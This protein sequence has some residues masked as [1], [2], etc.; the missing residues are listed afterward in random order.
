MG[1][2]DRITRVVRAHLN[3]LTAK[4]EDPALILEQAVR[5][6]EEDVVTLRSAVAKAI[7]AQKQQEQKIQ[8]S[9]TEKRSWEARAQLA[10]QKGDDE[11]AR[12]ALQ[13]KQSLDAEI[14][15]YTGLVNQHAA[16][17]AALKDNLLKVEAKLAE[18]KTKK[19]MLK[20]RADAAKAQEQLQSI[21]GGLKTSADSASA[22]F[23]R[24]E[25][26]VLQ[27][28]AK[29]QALSELSGADLEQQFKALESGTDVEAELNLLKSTVKVDSLPPAP[30]TPS[31]PPKSNTPRLEPS[32]SEPVKTPRKESSAEDDLLESLARGGSYSK[33]S[34]KKEEPVT[35]DAIDDLLGNIGRGKTNEATKPQKGGDLD[36]DALDRLVSGKPAK[37][38]KPAALPAD[39]KK[40]EPKDKEPSDAV[41]KLMKDLGLD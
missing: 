29:G 19:E 5:E 37:P 39:T 22:V 21:L 16:T 30:V 7:A 14:K 26:Q 31:L 6:M 17:V 34:P 20:A 24:M 10:V 33:Q 4:A 3:D 41:E 1:I 35:H 11:L 40:P 18:A 15:T 12:Q 36:D 27:L 38:Q 23:D 25:E 32:K 28:E 8:T 9:L 2:F 13:R